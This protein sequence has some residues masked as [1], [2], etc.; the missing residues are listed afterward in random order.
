MKRL[1]LLGFLCFPALAGAASCDV[2]NEYK[3]IC[4]AAEKGDAGAQTLLGMMYYFGD[5][6]KQDYHNAFQWFEKSAKQGNA[7]AQ[8]S[9]GV[10]Y[11]T[12]IGVRQNYYLAKK[13]FGKACDKGEQDGCDMYKKIKQLGY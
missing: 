8:V 1:L 10:K 9:L 6:A 4:L 5:G 7:N 2:A 12:G 11:V 3:S 13:W